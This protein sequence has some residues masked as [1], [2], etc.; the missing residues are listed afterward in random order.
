M[1]LDAIEFARRFLQHILPSN[2]YK[3]RYF[4]ILATAHINTKREQSIALVGKT[5]WLTV[6][7]GLTAYEVLRE[8]TGKDPLLC[9]VCKK[10]L[11]T[12]CEGMRQNE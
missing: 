1:E 3:I 6:L 9:P 7:E 12:R 10:G 11:M 2:F 8:L 5:M 4:G